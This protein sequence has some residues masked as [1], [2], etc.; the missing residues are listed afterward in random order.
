LSRITSAGLGLIKGIRHRLARGT[1]DLAQHCLIA[2]DLDVVLDV[3]EVRNTIKQAGEIS[4]ATRTL[5]R[6]I[7]QQL[8]LKRDEVNRSGIFHERRHMT[9][10]HTVRVEIE[11]LR[12][13]EF[14]DAVIV[15]VV[16]ED[17]A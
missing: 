8:I 7:P 10:D 9:E 12:S 13:K 14:D 1:D 3:D 16:D 15:F 5:E 17:G 6:R 11:V 2:N 4:D